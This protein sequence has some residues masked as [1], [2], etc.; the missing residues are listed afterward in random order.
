MPNH[1]H[2]I[3]YIPESAEML[4]A[5]RA[6]PT[7]PDIIGAFKSITTWQYT[8]LVK[9]NKASPFNKK[10]WQRNYY[11]HIIRNEESLSNVQKYV[12]ENPLDWEK[13]K[14]FVMD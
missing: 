14:L 8:R 10:I 12:V 11:D 13:D 5:T 6:A 9:Q 4:A 3:I 2:G 7:I 1:L